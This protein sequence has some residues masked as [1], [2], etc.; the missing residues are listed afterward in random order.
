VWVQSV[1]GRS[2]VSDPAAE[3]LD[4]SLRVLSRVSG[5]IAA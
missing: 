1:S 3:T 2:H 4:F 5:M